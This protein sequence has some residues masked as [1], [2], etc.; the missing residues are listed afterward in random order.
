MVQITFAFVIILG[1]LISVEMHEARQLAEQTERFR[2]E[3]AALTSIV[4]SLRGSELGEERSLRIAAEKELQRERL[5]RTWDTIKQ[6]RELRR[7]LIQFSDAE[8]VTLSDDRR[9]LPIEEGFRKLTAEVERVFLSGGEKVSA[10]EVHTLV[11]RVVEAAGF[12]LEAIRGEANEETLP[13]DAQDLFFNKEV[14]TRKNLRTL[15]L[16]IKGDLEQER[17]EL[18]N[19][20]YALVAK[21]AAARLD[22]LM[23]LPLD[24]VEID[25]VDT[26]AEMLEKVLEELGKTMALLPET[27]DRVRGKEAEAQE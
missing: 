10:R 5:L 6:Q 17:K 23:S 19:I 18:V 20:Q 11:L 27:A 3:N 4:A 25:A 13:D 7:G 24:E 1:Y 2:E 8:L 21:V 26:G 15:T 22:K 14:P 16:Q 9:C 12:E